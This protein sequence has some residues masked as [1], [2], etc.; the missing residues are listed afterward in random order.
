MKRKFLPVYFQVIQVFKK[1]LFKF[2]QKGCQAA[3]R[4]AVCF[5]DMA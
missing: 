1:Y 5:R 2:K 4:Q 3:A